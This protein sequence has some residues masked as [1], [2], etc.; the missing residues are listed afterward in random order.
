MKSENKRN[1]YEFR[2]HPKIVHKTSNINISGYAN[3]IIIK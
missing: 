1:Q 2:K 3:N